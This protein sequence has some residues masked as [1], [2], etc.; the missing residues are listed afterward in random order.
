MDVIYVLS[1]LTAV[2]ATILVVL[3]LK[4]HRLVNRVNLV[5]QVP[6]SRRIRG[7]MPHEIVH[8]KAAAHPREVLQYDDKGPAV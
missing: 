5:G 8:I 4:P 2:S 7:T 6:V 3:L 1:A